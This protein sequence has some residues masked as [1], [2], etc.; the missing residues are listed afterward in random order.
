MNTETTFAVRGPWGTLGNRSKGAVLLA[1]LGIIYLLSFL[2]VHFVDTA[3]S[4]IRL[5]ATLKTRHAF[6]TTS[7]SVLE[8]VNAVIHEHQVLDDGN[9]F[10]PGQGWRD[11]IAYAATLDL[12]E[13]LTIAVDISD[14]SAKI[15][16]RTI[17][18]QRLKFLFDAMEI[19][20]SDADKLVDSLLDWIDK[21]DAV[22][23]N[24]AEDAYY[25][26]QDPPVK[27]A[28][29]PLTSYETLRHIQGFKELFFDEDTNLP[30]AKYNQFVAATSLYHDGPMNLN[31]APDLV[32][33]ALAL[34][35]GFDV[36]RIDRALA[37]ND[38]IAG[39]EDDTYFGAPATSLDVVGLADNEA[40]TDK[41]SLLKITVH[42][43]QGSKTYQIS[44]L[45]QVNS[46][47]RDYRGGDDEDSDVGNAPGQ[48]EEL[49]DEDSSDTD[50]TNRGFADTIGSSINYPFTILS[51]VENAH[52]D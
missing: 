48:D 26:R 36:D 44:T 22:R 27:P 3:V 33:K 16:L 37:G 8:I 9:L 25:E 24:G 7:F 46:G 42:V 1:I 38:L 32:K 41:A 11:P 28:N 13:D 49:S 6:S 2:V 10:G 47:A 40:I 17:E 15:S 34:E 5:Q 21:D 51:I 31:G 43:S 12:P 30:N 20:F 23:L 29:E 39:T 35:I 18:R 50:G 19:D 45:T 52:L 14:E 4:Q